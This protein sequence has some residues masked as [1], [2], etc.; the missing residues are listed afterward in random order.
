MR[1]HLLVQYRLQD[2]GPVLMLQIVRIDVA[3]IGRLS[4]RLLLRMLPALTFIRHDIHPPLHEEHI[5]LDAFVSSATSTA[6]TPLACLLVAT[7][8]RALLCDLGHA[9]SVTV[10]TESQNA[11]RLKT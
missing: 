11:Y 1:T 8:M 7:P 9:P 3:G 6:A 10:H 4:S 2:F 5:A